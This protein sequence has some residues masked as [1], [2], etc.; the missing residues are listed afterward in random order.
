MNAF[1]TPATEFVI[2]RVLDAPREL[3]F[4]VWTEAEHLAH[5]WGPRGFQMGVH[6]LD[7]RPGGAFHYSMQAPTGQTMWGK[8]VFQEISAP[9]RI[10][11]INSF[12]D[13]AGGLTRHPLAPTWPLEV[14]NTL[15]LTE[16]NGKTTLTLRGVPVR[17]TDMECLTFAGGHASMQQGFGG[18]FDQLATYLAEVQA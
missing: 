8:F 5:W 14:S 1:D 11:F 18:T 17:A 3:V 9:E 15:T 16:Q 6:S 12:S 4:K 10:V 7:L 2:Q 13:A